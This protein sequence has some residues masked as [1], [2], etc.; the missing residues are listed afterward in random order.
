MREI[1]G[2]LWDSKDEIIL[3]TTNSFVKKNGELVMGRGAAK[4]AKE[5]F[6]DFSLDLGYEITNIYGKKYGI[7]IIPYDRYDRLLGA[8]QV[9]YNWWEDADLDLIKF[10]TE[11][12]CK[13]MN[14][15]FNDLK[16]SL[17]F[18]G[19]GNGRLK[20]DDVLDIVKVLPDNVSLYR[21]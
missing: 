1:I 6:P 9:K 21:K 17:N 5:L 13:E 3:V 10:S 8:F 12:L 7:I 14:E 2:D 15:N 18:P 4:E 20:Y 11:I 16:C 19:I